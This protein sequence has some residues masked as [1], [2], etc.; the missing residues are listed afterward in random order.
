[1][2]Q[3]LRGLFKP[4]RLEFPATNQVDARQAERTDDEGTLHVIRRNEL[5]SRE[6]SI[7]RRAR[8]TTTSRR[9]CT[10]IESTYTTLS[11]ATDRI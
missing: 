4:P 5:V 1:M 3:G 6:I 10:S 2:A 9:L 11:T 8:W 7:R